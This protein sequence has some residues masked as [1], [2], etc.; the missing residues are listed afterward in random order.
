[1]EKRD[2]GGPLICPNCREEHLVPKRGADAFPDGEVQP[3]EPGSP[4]E[5]TPPDFD[6]ETTCK[7]CDDLCRPAAHCGDCGGMICSDCLKQHGKMKALKQHSVLQ[8][9]GFS[10]GK[11]KRILMLQK[12]TKHNELLISFCEHCNTP[13]CVHCLKS[14]SHT[15][16]LEK[17]EYMDKARA[18]KETELKELRDMATKNLAA[19]KDYLESLELVEKNI[20]TYP[21]ELE[22][23]V[24]EA[25]DQYMREI[26]LWREQKLQEARERSLFMIKQVQ[27]VKVDHQNLSLQLEAGITMAKSALQCNRDIE[28]VVKITSA[29]KMLSDEVKKERKVLQ[30]PLVFS[31]T[32][33]LHLGGLKDLEPGDIDITLP[34]ESSMS[35]NFVIKVKFQVPFFTTPMIKVSYGSQ[36]QHHINL[37]MEKKRMKNGDVYSASFKPRC[38]GDHCVAV[39]INGVECAQKE[40]VS[41]CGAPAEGATVRPGPDWDGEEEDEK[42]GIVAD[43]QQKVGARCYYV[44]VVQWEGDVE[45]KSY[46]WGLD[47]VYKLEL[48]SDPQV[49]E[50]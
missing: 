7:N 37:H 20:D 40:S 34:E 2:S 31:K 25:F 24:N 15:D 48:C 50:V 29:T 17:I 27:E 3:L 11:L 45:M 39:Y 14:A 36:N 8:R 4:E 9:E 32:L 18:K 13:I 16:H 1:M 21:Q 19:C 42:T 23:S 43:V 22:M 33:R 38:A 41:V 49:S 26:N 47:D 6:T 46:N 28:A 12:C 35:E 30:K 10:P 44:L 5:P